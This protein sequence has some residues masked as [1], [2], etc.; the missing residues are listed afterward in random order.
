MRSEDS[1]QSH[2]SSTVEKLK[3]STS[4]ASKTSNKSSRFAIS[5]STPPMNLLM[6]RQKKIVSSRCEVDL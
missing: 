1:G 5:T 6:K 4:L 3:S 2:C